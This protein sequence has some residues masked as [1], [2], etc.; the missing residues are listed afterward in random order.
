MAKLY[1]YYGAM[2]SSKTANA[3]MTK[4]N[5]GEVGQKALLCKP[6][7]ETNQDSLLERIRAIEKQL[8][9]GI[10]QTNIKEKINSN[11]LSSLKP[12]LPL[13]QMHTR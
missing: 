3:L 6:A 13:L 11:A 1:Y 2:G 9:D 12:E 8:E 4:F 10:P 5:Y 7:M